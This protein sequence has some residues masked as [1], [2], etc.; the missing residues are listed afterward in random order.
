MH[1]QSMLEM[2]AFAKSHTTK[3]SKVLDIGSL[4]VNGSYKELFGKDY[5]GL[6][7]VDGPNVDVVAD[8]PYSWPLKDASFD[9]V[10]SGQALEHMEFPEKAMVE[11]K[12]VLVADGKAC[13][14]APSAGPF[15]AKPKDLTD[16]HRFSKKAFTKLATD[17]G[18]KI[19]SV[20][21]NKALPWC[22]AVMIIQ[23]AKK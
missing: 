2:K 5:T 14:I 18:F 17:A 13:I 10:V 15:P 19:I 8:K 6:D 12:R 4:G 20:T 16:R 7:I 22:D 21:V 3:K 11:I 9:V 23:K 1:P